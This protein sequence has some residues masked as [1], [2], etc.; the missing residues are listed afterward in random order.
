[1]GLRLL[2]PAQ[3]LTMLK[4]FLE[5]FKAVEVSSKVY[6]VLRI[7][8]G[9]PAAGHE[10]TED[11]T[12]LETG[13]GATISHT[14]GCYTGQEVIARQITYDK[15]TRQLVGLKLVA[16]ADVGD[17]I[18]LADTHQAIGKIT[19]AADS[20]RFGQ[21]ALGVIRKPYDQPGTKLLVGDEPDSQPGL[22]TELP[23]HT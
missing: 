15:V 12:P 14:K 21:I 19:S 4:E 3:Q 2:V 6:D 1:L 7:E 5:N 16:E 9:I 13:L 22:V 8:A 11:Y 10:L 20:P 18:R 23:F 17:D